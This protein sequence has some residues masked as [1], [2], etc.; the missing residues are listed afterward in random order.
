MLDKQILEFYHQLHVSLDRPDL[1]ILN[2]YRDQDAEI[3]KAFTSFYHKY[4]HDSNPR[5]L[6]L[7]INPGRKGAGITGVPFTDTHRLKDHCEIEI[8]TLTSY[9][10]SSVF[11]YKV[12]EAYGG[13]QKFY[14]DFFIGSISPL[15]YV[16]KNE[17]NNWVN[18]NFY[19]EPQIEKKLLPF[20]IDQ[21]KNQ[22]TLCSHPKKTMVLG[23]GKNVKSLQKINDAH[24][25]FEEIYSVE[26][27]RYIMQYKAKS[28]TIYIDKYLMALECLASN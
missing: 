1:E 11:V 12:I 27:P 16:K 8:T 17:K 28:Q 5:G 15:G 20:I 13:A 4:Y 6:I 10:P 21:L 24:H 25:L 14:Q 3:E 22:K 2:P 18:F 9:E 26:H 19:D 23:S 7:G